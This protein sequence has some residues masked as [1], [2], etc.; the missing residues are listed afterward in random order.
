MAL[1]VDGYGFWHTKRRCILLE[2]WQNDMCCWN[3]YND[4]KDIIHQQKLFFLVDKSRGRA[5]SSQPTLGDWTKISIR[6]AI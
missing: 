5:I 3:L 4:R 6:Y 1:S 2:Y